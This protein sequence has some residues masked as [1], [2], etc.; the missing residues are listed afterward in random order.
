M[1]NSCKKFIIALTGGIATGKSLA[2]RHLEKLGA[3]VV[4]TDIIA[5][6]VVKPGTPALKEI[7]NQWGDDVINPDGTL[8]RQALGKIIFASDQAREKLNL[9]THPPIRREM[10]RQVSSAQSPVVVLVIPLLFETGKKATEY[11]EAWLVYCPERLQLER[12]MK[13]DGI[14]EE[15]ARRKVGSQIPIE[16]KKEWC[17]VVIDNSKSQEQTLQQVEDEWKKLLARE[18]IS[19][20]GR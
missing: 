10:K 4:D 7:R 15:T 3:F 2:A 6:Q 16:L 9:I 11:D 5:R 8:N 14:D 17:P 1:K 20:A 12:L 13:R 19:I 18:R